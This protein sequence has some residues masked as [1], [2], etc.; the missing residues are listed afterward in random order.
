MHSLREAHATPHLSEWDRWAAAE[1]RRLTA[2][3]NPNPIPNPNPNPDPNPNLIPNP[4]PTSGA[5]CSRRCCRALSRAQGL[6]RT[7]GRRGAPP[8]R[9]RARSTR[10]RR[11]VS[12]RRRVAPDCVTHANGRPRGA[13]GHVGEE[14]EVQLPCGGPQRRAAGGAHGLRPAHGRRPASAVPPQLFSPRAEDDRPGV[15]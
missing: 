4:N 1:Y 15:D 9:R 14:R 7:R 12:A 10:R 8:T 6:L 13:V 3:P 5:P 11:A 2:D